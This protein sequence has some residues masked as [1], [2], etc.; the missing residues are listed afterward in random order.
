MDHLNEEIEEIGAKAKKENFESKLQH[1]IPIGRS[2]HNVRDLKE[3]PVKELSHISV[4]NVAVISPHM[5][6]KN[7]NNKS[8]TTSTVQKI[9]TT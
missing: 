8:K 7:G 9:T 4:P 5:Y 6:H 1:K 2:P 3:Q